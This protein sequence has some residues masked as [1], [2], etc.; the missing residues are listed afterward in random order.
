M[1]ATISSGTSSAV[2]SAPTVTR[3]PP[4]FNASTGLPAFR[5]AASCGHADE[6]AAPCPDPAGRDD[7]TSRAR[8]GRAGADRRRRRPGCAPLPGVLRRHHPQ[9][10]HPP[11]LRPRVRGVPRLVHGRRGAAAARR[12]LDRDADPHPRC[13]EREAAPRRRAPPVRLAGD[14]P[15]GA[16]EPGGFGARAG[17]C[18]A[19]GQNAGAGAGRGARCSTASTPR[20]IPD[21]ATGR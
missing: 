21:C 17:A 3:S 18:R 13:A 9:R 15:G 19:P 20:P 2:R 16:G 11:G 14:R 1:P 12:H 6:R 5:P 7:A 8:A 10:Q 4:T